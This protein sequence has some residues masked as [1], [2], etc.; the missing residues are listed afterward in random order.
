MCDTNYRQRLKLNI[1]SFANEK[2]K[3]KDLYIPAQIYSH[4]SFFWN[5]GILYNN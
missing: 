4:I 1:S 2:L 3:E 5:R